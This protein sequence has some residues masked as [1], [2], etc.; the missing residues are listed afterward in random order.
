MERL[1]IVTVVFLRELVIAI[2]RP[3]LTES[4]HLHCVVLWNGQ[5]LAVARDLKY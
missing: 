3:R 5:S 4:A 1:S 2:N